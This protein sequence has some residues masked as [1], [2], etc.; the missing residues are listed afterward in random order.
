MKTTNLSIISDG[1]LNLFPRGNFVKSKLILSLLTLALLPAQLCATVVSMTRYARPNGTFITL[2]GDMH[3]PYK[4]TER[5]QRTALIQ[6]LRNNEKAYLIAEDSLVH[7]GM[8]LEEFNKI[9]ASGCNAIFLPGLVQEAHSYGIQAMSCE[10]RKNVNR[11]EFVDL[12]IANYR[13]MQLNPNSI[14]DSFKKDFEQLNDT[15]LKL[16]ELATRLINMPGTQNG[17]CFW[18][19]EQCNA[20]TLFD[21]ELEDATSKLFN[22]TL[23][24]QVFNDVL[25]DKDIYVCL[26]D[27]HIVFLENHFKML[28]ISPLFS[29]TPYRDNIKKFDLGALGCMQYA[30]YMNGY[31]DHASK[32][33]QSYQAYLKPLILFN[34]KNLLSQY[35][36]SSWF[37]WFMGTPNNANQKPEKTSKRTRTHD[38]NTPRNANNMTAAEY[39][40]WSNQY[41]KDMK[42][43]SLPISGFG[44]N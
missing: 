34:F 12:L 27:K 44:D 41:D 37:G 24:A 42:E 9:N 33:V 31:A 39:R 8:S 10:F 40:Q 20:S 22:Y 6:H 1:G 5:E 32:E 7:N 23:I 13:S 15:L 11:Y 30:L 35:H 29:Y 14:A 25:Q 21:E 28:G 36:S 43:E 16:Q 18:G 3:M 19:Y 38:T 26:G 2:I 4:P 17:T